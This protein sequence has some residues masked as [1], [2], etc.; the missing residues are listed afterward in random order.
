MWMAGLVEGCGY[1]SGYQHVGLCGGFGDP[2]V[3]Y[4]CE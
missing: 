4:C 2:A 1:M 3:V